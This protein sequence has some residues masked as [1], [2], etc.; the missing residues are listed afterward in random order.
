MFLDFE[1]KM[2]KDPA[3][4]S[5]I[6]SAVKKIQAAYKD[7]P[8]GVKYREIYKQ[9]LHEYLVISDF[10]LAPLLGYYYP[11]Y[12]DGPYSLKDFPFAHC[13]YM[14]NLGENSYT[15]LRGSRQ[16][17]KCVHGNTKIRIKNKKN[18][19]IKTVSIKDLY[20]DTKQAK[21]PK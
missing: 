10:N 13:Y 7:L 16:I 5:K 8:K 1:F 2:R 11:N 9:A 15:T 4:R 19:L 17:G 21:E 18:G 6:E 12:P 20:L 3:F 14:L